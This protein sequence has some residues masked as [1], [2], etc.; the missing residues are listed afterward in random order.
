MS[1]QGIERVALRT[2]SS[3][4]SPELSRTPLL[5]KPAVEFTPDHRDDDTDRHHDHRHEGDNEDEGI[6][7]RAGHVEG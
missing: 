6:F 1:A 5:C 7:W 2:T 4:S 3:P